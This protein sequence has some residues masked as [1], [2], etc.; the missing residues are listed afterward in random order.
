MIVIVVLGAAACRK[1]RKGLP[2]AAIV[3]SRTEHAGART[4]RTDLYAVAS[5]GSG[6]R[7]LIRGADD[8]AVAPDGTQI[9]FVRNGSVWVA[10]RD[11]SEQ[12]R[13]TQPSGAQDRAYPGSATMSDSAP[14]W[15]PDGRKVYFSRLSWKS[16][17]ASLYSVRVD[18]THLVCLTHAS[19]ESALGTGGYGV[20]HD[21][22]APSRD[23]RLIAFTVVDDCIHGSSQ[24]IE[25]ITPRGGATPLGFRMPVGDSLLVSGPAWSPNGHSLAYSVRNLDSAKATGVYVSASHRA[26]PQLVAGPRENVVEAISPSWSPDGRRIAY[27]AVAAGRGEIWV[28][29]PGRTA[30][31]RITDTGADDRNPAWLPP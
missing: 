19:S 9:A 24:S 22:P 10:L 25:A 29:A 30:P 17:S 8:A 6:L 23:G 20:C 5:D 12:R 14:A 4:A 2:E 1:E 7:R 21:E 31:R 18:G 27:V 28:T 13:V 26:R 15:S 16:V 3:F 11:A